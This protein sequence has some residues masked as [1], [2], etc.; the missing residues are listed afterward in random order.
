MVAINKVT[1]GG[2][3]I[4]EG[5]KFFIIAGPCVIENFETL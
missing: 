4:Q 3:T 2:H 1:A 5:G